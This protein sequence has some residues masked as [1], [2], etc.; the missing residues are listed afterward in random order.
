[1]HTREY[2]FADSRMLSLKFF[3]RGRETYDPSY[4]VDTYSLSCYRHATTH[5]CFVKNE[6]EMF[7]E[8]VPKSDTSQ[9]SAD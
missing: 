7:C 4:N 2:R 8:K 1:M 6:S 9:G 5:L 3:L